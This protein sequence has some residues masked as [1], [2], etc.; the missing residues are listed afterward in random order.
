MLPQQ[1]AGQSTGLPRAPLPPC[2]PRLTWCLCG[3]RLELA[4]LPGFWFGSG[5]AALSQRFPLVTLHLT[6]SHAS[7][8]RLAALSGSRKR[9]GSVRGIFLFFC[10][11]QIRPSSEASRSLLWRLILRRFGSNHT[12]ISNFCSPFVA[13][14]EPP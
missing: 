12:L 7:T 6:Q 5:V 2:P 4:C 11:S 9:K 8:T 3:A 14:G 1:R 13:G 10:S